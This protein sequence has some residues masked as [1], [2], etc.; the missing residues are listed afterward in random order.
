MNLR[1]RL[2][3]AL[4]PPCTCSEISSTVPA[5][6]APRRRSSG[7]TGVL[8][9]TLTA[10][11]GTVC[12]ATAPAAQAAWK[13]VTVAAAPLSVARLGSEVS[14]VSGAGTTTRN[15]YS[16]AGL[17]VASTGDIDVVNT[18]TV[19]VT[20][21]ATITMASLVAGTTVTQCSQPWQRWSCPGTQTLL[22]SSA[23]LALPTLNYTWPTTTAPG[24]HLY[25]R[26]AVAGVLGGVSVTLN[27]VSPRAAG[28][29]TTT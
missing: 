24:Q 20:L 7:L 22:A 28:D 27:P 13:P 5:A 15:T 9:A 11:L 25:V 26:V 1:T 29:R 10:A 2:R 4:T 19:P 12:L 17:L 18:S 16:V 21:S 3:S 6:T 14:M 23:L 8:A